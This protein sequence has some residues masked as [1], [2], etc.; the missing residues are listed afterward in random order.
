MSMMT[1]EEK[2]TLFNK[3]ALRKHFDRVFDEN[4]MEMDSDQ[5]LEPSF[6]GAELEESRSEWKRRSRQSCVRK[7]ERQSSG[8]IK[9]KR[10]SKIPDDDFVH[11]R[12]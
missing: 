11:V 10:P 12:E 6:E 7:S 2:S 4:S 9:K 8:I 5:S 3:S 1:E